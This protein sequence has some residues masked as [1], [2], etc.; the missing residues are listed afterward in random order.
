M[1]QQERHQ[2]GFQWPAR[3]KWFIMRSVFRREA[4]SPARCRCSERKVSSTCL[5]IR[6]N[7]II[8]GKSFAKTTPDLAVRAFLT[9]RSERPRRFRKKTSAADGKGLTRRFPI[10][11]DASLFGS[12]LD[13][14]ALKRD[15]RLILP[16]WTLASIRY[17]W[18]IYL[19]MI[20]FYV[21]GN[22]SSNG[23]TRYR[24]KRSKASTK[25]RAKLGSWS[26]LYRFRVSTTIH[27]Y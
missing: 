12:V 17:N 26:L 4:N 14:F 27:A 19:G 7:S 1:T 20:L 9:K 16:G 8:R 23:Q 3:P 5:Y 18:V 22:W 11:H 25:E 24:N 21:T 2:T 10:S 6:C 13:P 15:E